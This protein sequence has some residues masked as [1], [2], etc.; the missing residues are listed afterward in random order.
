MNR[1]LLL[2]TIG[3]VVVA[4]AIGLNFLFLREE[5]DEKPQAQQLAEQNEKA[6]AKNSKEINLGAINEMPVAAQGLIAPSFDVTR[7]N[8]KGDAVIAGRAMP[9]AVVAILDGGKE[10]GVVTADER[11]EWVFVPDKPLP[12]GSRLLSLE[13]RVKGLQPLASEEVVVLVAP[14]KDKDI[15]GRIATGASQALALKVGKDR[16]GASAVL[17]KPSAADNNQLYPLAVDAVDYDDNGRLFISG[18]T[19][20]NGMLQIYL[21]NKFIVLAVAG[22]DGAWSANPNAPAAF[23]DYSLRV[24]QVDKNGKVQARV[25]VPFSRLERQKEP[26]A[27]NAILVQPGSSLWRLARKAYGDGFQFTVIYE[28]NKDQIKNPDLIYPGQV[29]TLPQTN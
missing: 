23:G 21:N 8:P 15:A 27:A 9:G 22:E 6:T 10:I 3:A 26:M 18:R 20:A 25:E 24:D 17:Q 11:G 14:E 13:M 1:P 28:A 7:I 12:S 4:V 29:F 5:N 19:E 16:I 2:T